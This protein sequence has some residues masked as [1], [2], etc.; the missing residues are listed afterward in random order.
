MPQFAP[1]MLR[2]MRPE[3]YLR[4]VRD[5]R[6]LL[7]QIEAHCDPQTPEARKVL[8][9]SIYRLSRLMRELSARHLAQVQERER[10]AAHNAYI[11]RRLRGP[12]HER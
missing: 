4:I 2:P 11:E 6:D 3:Q 1:R 5:A 9:Q 10:D 7:A 8:S 12:T